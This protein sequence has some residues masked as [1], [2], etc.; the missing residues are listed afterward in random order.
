MTFTPNGDGVNDTWVLD[1]I[2]SFK[3]LVMVYNRWGQVLYTTENFDGTWD[4]TVNGEQL[5]DGA[6][7]YTME[8]TEQNGEVKYL[9]GSLNIIR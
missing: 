4:G 5:P 7:F 1:C 8:I 6:Y 2:A 3:H 9:K